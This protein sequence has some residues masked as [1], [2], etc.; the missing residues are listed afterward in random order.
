MTLL[1]Y[2]LCAAYL[3]G[4]FVLG[5][6]F[7]RSQRSARD[8]FL[9]GRSLG[10]LPLGLSL[11]VTLA[12]SIGF[13][14]IPAAAF[15][16]GLIML[17]SL[18]AIPLAF[19]LVV[20]VF[21][22]FYRRLRVYTAYE[23]LERRFDLR[24]RLA[25]SGLFILWRVTWMAATVYVAAMVIQVVTGG[26]VP[27][28][29]TAV[30][31]GLVATSYTTLGGMRAVVWTDVAQFFV[32]FGSVGALLVI[33]AGKEPAGI[34]ALWEAAHTAGKM[35]MTAA[36]AGWEGAGWWEKFQFY[37][38]TDFTA[39]AIVVSFTLGKLGNYCIDQ[40][41]VQRYLS[42]KSLDNARKGFLLNCVAFALFFTLMSGVGVALFVFSKNGTVP[43]TLN[44]DQVFPYF[45]AHYMPVGVAGL[46]LSAVMAAAM[47][48][49][50]SG[51]N[52]CIAAISNDFYNRLWR[53]QV[54]LENT[55]SEGEE[56]VH[57]FL[58]RVCSV[59]LGVLVLFLACFVGGIGDAFKIALKLVNSFIGPLFG[60]F[61]LAMFTRRAHAS[62]VFWGGILGVA[63]TALTVFAERLGEW[64]MNIQGSVAATARGVVG[65]FDVGF[66]WTSVA[67]FVATL[68]FGYGLSL[69]LPSSQEPG[70]LSWTFRNVMSQ[71][72]P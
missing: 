1:D 41:M 58:A 7:V 39:L 30:I 27:L 61:V 45:I 25:A 54:S 11:M 69:L 33:V 51:L 31:L 6:H 28:V 42:A 36:A 52:S 14:A 9:A 70:G 32:I 44:P 4:V 10:W 12:S 68:A 29:G 18:L 49:V 62:G 55:Q 5:A 19:P 3:L 21:L 37:V 24:I 13:I 22:P 60:L 59:V 46:V 64:L 71:Q 38:Y 34:P 67:G 65:L 16:S 2:A 17:W 40:V 57:V 35:R 26:A 8:F 56:T 15:R 20:W 66:L 48:S 47:S 53:R 50:D 43:G 72:E 23:Y 63:V